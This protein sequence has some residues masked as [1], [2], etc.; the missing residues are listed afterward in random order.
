MGKKRLEVIVLAHNA[1]FGQYVSDIFGADGART[2]AA[3][4]KISPPYVSS[5][6]SGFVPDEA[7]LS[8]IVLAYGLKGDAA[9][10]LYELAVEEKP[11]LNPEAIVQFACE[12]AGYNT[13]QRL[14]VLEC[15]RRQAEP[16]ANHSAA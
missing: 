5:I 3:K 8:R 9:R 1:E 10:R 2:V 12:A 14:A 13:M 11:D 4:V 15:F 7:V 16:E 6:K